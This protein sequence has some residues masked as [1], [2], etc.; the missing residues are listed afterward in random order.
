MITSALRKKV[1]QFVDH[2]GE[3]K[4]RAIYTLAIEHTDDEFE[5]TPD[6][7]KLL[8]RLDKQYLD[9]DVQTMNL[10]QVRKVIEKVLRK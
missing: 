1:R 5:F 8:D 7:K 4:L 3:Q 2:A 6:E 9:G 10:G